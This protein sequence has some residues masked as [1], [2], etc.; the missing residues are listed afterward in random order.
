MNHFVHLKGYMFIA[1]AAVLWGLLG[2]ISRLAL[3]EGV[4][5]LEIAFWRGVLAWVLFGGQAVWAGQTR[6]NL[7]DM[8]ALFLF[9]LTGVTLF[10]GSFQLSV[11]SGGAAL[12]AVLLY[13]APAWVAIMARVF[14]MEPLTYVKLAAVALT[15][16]GVACISLGNKGMDGNVSISAVL[17]GLT[18]GFCY[19]MYYVLGKPF[20][21]GYT[22]PNLFL[23]LLPV[24]S[25][26]LLPFVS[27]VH[28]TPT[29]W[30]ALAAIAF[31]CTYCAYHSYYAGLKL[32]QAARASI[33]ATLEPVAAAVVA[34]FWWGE[35]FS[36]LGWLGAASILIGVVLTIQERA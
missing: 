13:T 25:L 20:S 32:L 21:K 34:Y 12:A 15:I 2:P 5:P 35:T 24:G 30:A 9:A 16:V 14:Y 31:V 27:F 36:F 28:K 11:Q 4:T 26:L 17:F 6:L 23:F 22:A 10:Y 29:A 33:V 7:R 8:P 3:A 18:A 1:L 19:S